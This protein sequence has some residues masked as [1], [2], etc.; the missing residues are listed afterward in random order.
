M[1]TYLS[2]AARGLI[3][4][5]ATGS[6]IVGK[7][8]PELGITQAVSGMDAAGAAR[9]YMRVS[10]WK[11]LG[12]TEDG[13]FFRYF[14]L[15]YLG[16]VVYMVVHRPKLGGA[17]WVVFFSLAEYTQKQVGQLPN[18]VYSPSCDNKAAYCQEA[19]NFHLIMISL[20]TL[21]VFL[22]YVKMGNSHPV[23]TGPRPYASYV[24]K[25]KRD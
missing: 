15:L 17:M 25:S 8:G 9:D 3:A 21:V 4:V 2:L 19:Y 13:V 22:E 6:S 7:A 14:A 18:A 5:A 11:D 20:G 23:Q 16:T 12:F 24:P 1:V 10:P